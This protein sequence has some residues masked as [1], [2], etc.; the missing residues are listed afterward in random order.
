[1]KIEIRTTIAPP[2]RWAK[3]DRTFTGWAKKSIHQLN[4]QRA[5]TPKKDDLLFTVCPVRFQSFGEMEHDSE[6]GLA[7]PRFQLDLPSHPVDQSSHDVDP[8]SFAFT[9][10]VS[11]SILLRNLTGVGDLGHSPH[12]FPVG[13]DGKNTSFFGD[14]IGSIVQEII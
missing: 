1:L 8:P 10:E 3:W 6:G 5:K 9:K 12:L 4:L 13:P 7:F 11:V 2:H 14:S